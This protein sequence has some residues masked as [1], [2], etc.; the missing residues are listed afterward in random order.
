MSYDQGAGYRATYCFT[1]LTNATLALAAAIRVPIHRGI[2]FAAI[3]DVQVTPTVAVVN[4]TGAMVVQIGT[5][6]TSGKYVAQS[7]GTT[8]GL[9]VGSAYGVADVDGRVAL[10]NP[11]LPP[12]VNSSGVVTQAT[13][14][15]LN[16]DGDTVG[17]N[18]TTLKI[19][20]VVGTGTP[21]GT[22]TLNVTIRWF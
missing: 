13:R 22:V 16:N 9:T 12:A 8:A 3:E 7:V 2:R 14:I 21:S 5:P 6:T 10:Y 20:T 4:T 17:T 15:D 11:D 1:G 19:G 18:L